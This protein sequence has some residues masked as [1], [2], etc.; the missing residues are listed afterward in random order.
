MGKERAIGDSRN[1]IHLFTEVTK[2]KEIMLPK[3]L[4]F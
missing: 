4:Y 1:F 3:Y 2:E